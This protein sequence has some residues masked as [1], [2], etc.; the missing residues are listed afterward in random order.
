MS[1][2]ETRLTRLCFYK[3]LWCR[4]NLIERFK[5]W[6]GVLSDITVGYLLWKTTCG[7]EMLL[8]KCYKLNNVMKIPTFLRKSD[9]SFRMTIMKGIASCHPHPKFRLNNFIEIPP[10]QKRMS[11]F[12]KADKSIN[13]PSSPRLVTALVGVE[14]ISA[15]V[16][17]NQAARSSTP[18]LPCP[19]SHPSGPH[20]H[21][22]WASASAHPHTHLR[23][24][25][26]HSGGGCSLALLLLL[27]L[28]IPH[29]LYKYC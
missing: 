18:S 22:L 7:K 29:C 28:F 2:E 15:N 9:N 10:F 23:T 6:R 1:E 5:G 27:L 14:V 25:H 20:H 16:S 26:P 21:W 8:R 4:L 17:I 3:G 11:S 19:Y 13:L 12:Q 24:A